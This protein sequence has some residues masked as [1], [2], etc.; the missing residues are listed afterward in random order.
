[1]LVVRIGDWRLAATRALR[2]VRHRQFAI[3]NQRHERFQPLAD[4]ICV[5]QLVLM[6]QRLPSGEEEQRGGA[7]GQR[8]Q[9]RG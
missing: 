7:R 9:R 5:R 3:H 1:M 2:R 8:N 4:D 6:R